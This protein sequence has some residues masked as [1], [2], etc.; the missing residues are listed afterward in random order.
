MRIRKESDQ[1]PQEEILLIA[2]AS[3]ALAHPARVRIFRYIYNANRNRLP[4]CNKDIVSAFEYSQ[5][6]ISQHLKKL[7]FS[8]LVRVQKKDN[9][10]YYY[11]NIGMLGKYLD[12]VKKLQ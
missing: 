9:F 2:K 11:V 12:A 10:S 8:E 1:W 3:D 4:V 5:A 6:T 7:I